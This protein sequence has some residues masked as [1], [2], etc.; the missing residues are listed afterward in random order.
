MKPTPKYA[1]R[2]TSDDPR[3]VEAWALAEAARRLID[4]SRDPGNPDALQ[5]ALQLNQRLWT[6]FQASITEDDCVLPPELR[7]N[8]AALSLLVDRETMAR[9][10][11][12]DATKLDTLISINRNVS[13]GLG[14][15][16]DGA[17][18]AAPVAPQPVVQAVPQPPRPAV[19][20]EAPQPPRESLRISI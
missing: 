15:K 6:I 19:S 9:L 11:D 5:A 14:V 8:I 4:A 17:P 16:L 10:A 7:T 20:G 18:T 12:L 3:D 1:S 2:P 13:G